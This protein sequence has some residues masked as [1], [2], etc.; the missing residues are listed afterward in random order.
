MQQGCKTD[1][2]ILAS[3][4]SSLFW[5]GDVPS[6]RTLIATGIF[7]FSP[8]GIQA[9]YKIPEIGFRWMTKIQPQDNI[10]QNVSHLDSG[11]ILIYDYL[12]FIIYNLFMNIDFNILYSRC[13]TARIDLHA[14]IRAE[15]SQLM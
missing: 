15:K 9:P 13:D 14:F 12:L 2:M 11:L 5:L 8:S 3:C 1:A 4:R 7:T 6:W 10:E